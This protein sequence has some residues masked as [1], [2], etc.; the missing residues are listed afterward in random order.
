ML[1]TFTRSLRLTTKIYLLC[2]VYVV[3][4]FLC[5]TLAY[6]SGDPLVVLGVGVGFIALGGLLAWYI[7]D[8]VARPLGNFAARLEGLSHGNAGLLKWVK[9]VDRKDELGDVARAFNEFADRLSKIIGE[10]LTAASALSSASAQLRG[11]AQSLSRATSEQVASVEQTTASLEQINASISQNVENSRQMERMALD[12]VKGADESSDSASRSVAAM[13]TI[14]EKNKI[15]EEI[16][17]QTNLLA[18]NAAIE[19]ARAGENGKGF[20]VVATEVRKLAERS[21]NAAKEIGVLTASSVQVAER[22]GSLLEDLLPAITK[23]AEL[24]QEVATASR[25]QASGV[26]Q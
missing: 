13:K 22:S 11:S 17:Y 5:G 10:V 16:A 25:E 3:G 4:Y 1:R 6:S 12:G 2:A 9:A 21:Q 20:A 23:T 18:L 8:G 7:A 24:V 14:A 26:A 19:A 15:I